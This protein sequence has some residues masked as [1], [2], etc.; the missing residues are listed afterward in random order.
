[1]TEIQTDLF[2]EIHINIPDNPT[3]ERCCNHLLNLIN[4]DKSLLDG[5]SVSDIDRQ[6]WLALS[7]DN[8]LIPIIK[9]GDIDQFKEWVMNHKLCYDFEV[10][11]RAR[12]YL[13]EKDYVRISQKAIVKA[14]QNRQRL[15]PS[16]K[17][18]R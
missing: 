6:L 11:S 7:F 3:L 1:M 13:L 2:N 16:F 18:K 8:N 9:S 15:T 10:V 12:R 4:N 17:N 5:D 14:E